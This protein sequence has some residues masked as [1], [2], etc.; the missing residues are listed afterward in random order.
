[1]PSARIRRPSASVLMISMV[2]PFDAVTTSPGFVALPEGMFSVV[3][4]MAMTLIA[5]FSSAMA[6][7][8]PTTAAPPPMSDFMYSMWPAGLAPAVAEDDH[9]GRFV[10]S[11]GHRQQRAHLQPPHVLHLQHLQLEPAPL[12]EVAHLLHEDAR[13]EGVRR[14]VH[15]LPHL[16]G[17]IG[18]GQPGGHRLGG[19]A[20][21]VKADDRDVLD[22]DLRFVGACAQRPLLKVAER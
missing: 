1:M 16:V 18:Q 4:T 14:K 5:G 19:A 3:G 12:G 13:G 22:I 9:F 21:G 8:A 20:F 10:L 7:M 11:F 15:P 6:R 17:G 2:F